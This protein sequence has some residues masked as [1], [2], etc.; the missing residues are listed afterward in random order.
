MGNLVWSSH[1]ICAYTNGLDAYGLISETPA[2][3][4]IQIVHIPGV[5]YARTRLS[6][7]AHSK[8][9]T[10]NFKGISFFATQFDYWTWKTEIRRH[11]SDP[12]LYIGDLYYSQ[13]DASSNDIRIRQVL[14][15]SFEIG[16]PLQN[17]V[18]RNGYYYY[19]EWTMTFIKVGKDLDYHV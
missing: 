16:E 13:P 14:L 18:P 5:P 1:T 4:D 7:F 8:K 6:A 19:A 2:A 9:D 12:L 17:I 3:S 15:E 11:Q 10:F